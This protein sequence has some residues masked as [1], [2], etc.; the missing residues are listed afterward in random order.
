VVNEFH[1]I[2]SILTTV[3]ETFDP[4]VDIVCSG[5]LISKQDIITTQHCL[6]NKLPVQVHIY[7]GSGDLTLNQGYHANWWISYDE[8]ANHNNV[9][10]QSAGHE[11]TMLRVNY[12]VFFQI[13]N[14]E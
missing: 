4:L 1:Y 7:M 2:A 6:K 11:I 14:C 13:I 8:W 5:T 9:P 3:G 12:T 10:V